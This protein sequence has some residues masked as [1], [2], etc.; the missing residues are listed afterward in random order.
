VIHVYISDLIHV[1]VIVTACNLCAQER[2][3]ES[4]DHRANG[5]SGSS[6]AVPILGDALRM[7]FQNLLLESDETV[8]QCSQRVWRLLLQVSGTTL[9]FRCHGLSS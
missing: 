9:Y 3:L 5:E 6:W 2:L 1:L 7:V 4:G 8:I